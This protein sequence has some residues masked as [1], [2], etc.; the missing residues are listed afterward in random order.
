MNRCLCEEMLKRESHCAYLTLTRNATR[1]WYDSGIVALPPLAMAQL[2]AGIVIAV[3]VRK[4]N[5][6][7]VIDKKTGQ[8]LDLNDD[9]E[10]WE[11]D[12]LNDEPYGWGVLYDKEGE[13]AYEGF[14]IG[15][16]NVCYGIQYYSDIQK[17][18]Y[19]GEWCEGKRW[20]RGTQYDRDGN[21]VF[22]GEWMNDKIMETRVVITNKNPEY[23]LHN[24]VEHFIVCCHCCNEETWKRLDLSFLSNLR[25]LIINDCCFQNVEEVELIGL[26]KL[27]RVAIGNSSFSM[28]DPF[29]DYRDPSGH[30]YLKNCDRL[31]ELKIG[32]WSFYS[33]AMVEIENMARLEVIEIGDLD[34]Q[35]HDF[36]CAS[37]EL[38]SASQRMK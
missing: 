29:L 16:V 15:D 14:R 35:G 7:N 9:G 27:E 36:L 11:G 5:N 3:N 31:R 33:Y 17:V 30:F 4:V 1:C 22:D 26:S 34:G 32:Y 10:R 21:I 12:V 2:N 19:E 37:L 38:K 23:L 18:E 13:K 28:D 20:G 25:E 24:H 8:V 6:E